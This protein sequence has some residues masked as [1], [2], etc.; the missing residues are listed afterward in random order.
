MWLVNR[1]RPRGIGNGNFADYLLRYCRHLPHAISGTLEL[2][3]TG[4]LSTGPYSG[5]I[6]LAVALVALSCSLNA[7][8][9]AF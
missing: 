9:A 8:S 5:V 3:R 6:V 7:R 4:A 1:S 2:G